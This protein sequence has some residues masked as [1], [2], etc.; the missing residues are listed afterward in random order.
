MPEQI[1][2][3]IA[4]VLF[5]CGVIVAVGGAA[6][7]IKKGS[8]PLLKPFN[9]MK[10][11][12]DAI[13][14]RSAACAKKFA[15]DEKRLNEHELLLQELAEDNKIMLESIA[16]LMKHAETGNSTGEVSEGREALEKYLINR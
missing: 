12:I 7:Y 16:L 6:A 11:E 8:K 4:T 1:T 9:D 10:C 14:K 2:I 5:W 15:N 3:D 13:E